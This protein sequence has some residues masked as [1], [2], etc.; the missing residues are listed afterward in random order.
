[1]LGIVSETVTSVS[2]YQSSRSLLY[3]Q[4]LIPQISA[5]SAEAVSIVRTVFFVFYAI[6]I[7]DAVKTQNERQQD[8]IKIRQKDKRTNVATR[9]DKIVNLRAKQANKKR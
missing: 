9:V 5:G 3:I 4:G 2:R 6:A 1:M 8:K 7:V